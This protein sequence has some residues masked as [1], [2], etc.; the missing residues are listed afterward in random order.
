[1]ESHNLLE[2]RRLRVDSCQKVIHDL[3]QRLGEVETHPK[4]IEQLQRLDELLELIDPSTVSEEDLTRIERST[5]QLLEELSGLFSRQG[6]EK[7]Y[8]STLN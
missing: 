7:L 3:S 5:N 4:I 6:I 2:Y 1:M 8:G